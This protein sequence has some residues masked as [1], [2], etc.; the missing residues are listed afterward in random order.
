MVIETVLEAPKIFDLFLSGHAR[1][2]V[3]TATHNEAG[4]D[5]CGI[6][7]IGSIYIKTPCDMLLLL[8]V[9]G[10]TTETQGVYTALPVIIFDDFTTASQYVNFEFKVKSSAMKILTPN[11]ELV[12][13]RTDSGPFYIHQ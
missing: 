1:H 11:T 5:F 2:E 6:A 9:L 12:R 4:A 3:M 13:T 7:V 8:V 10:Y